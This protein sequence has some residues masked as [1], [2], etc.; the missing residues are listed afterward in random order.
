MV[1]AES[2]RAIEPNRGE[3]PS[4]GLSALRRVQE[5]VEIEEALDSKVLEE[6]A[7]DSKEEATPSLENIKNPSP[8]TMLRISTLALLT[9]LSSAQ[10][11]YDI[12]GDFFMFNKRRQSS[13]GCL[14]G[15]QSDDFERFLTNRV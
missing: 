3:G 4:V 8:V 15:C 13:S 12:C 6:E 2:N 9:T 10:V 7:L 5:E 14:S 11:S 1:C